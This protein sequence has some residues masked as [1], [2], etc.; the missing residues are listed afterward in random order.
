MFLVIQPFFVKYITPHVFIHSCGAFSENINCH[1][2]KE[3]KLNEKVRPNFWPVLYVYAPKNL[4]RR[5]FSVDGRF[6]LCSFFQQL[7]LVFVALEPKLSPCGG[8]NSLLVM[9][10]HP[11]GFTSP[12]TRLHQ[13]SWLLSCSNPSYRRRALYP[14]DRRCQ[15]N[16]GSFW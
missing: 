10:H 8:T 4:I 1:E 9:A 13:K 5:H 11:I 14:R 15:I 12:K 6:S 2:N 16:P 7:Y 3:N